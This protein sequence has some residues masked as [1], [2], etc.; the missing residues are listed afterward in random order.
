MIDNTLFRTV[1]YHPDEHQV[2]TSGTDR[3]VSFGGAQCRAVTISIWS[4]CLSCEPK[5]WYAVEKQWS[6]YQWKQVDF[7][8]VPSRMLFIS[9]QILFFPSCLDSN[10]QETHKN[11]SYVFLVSIWKVGMECVD[12]ERKWKKK[13]ANTGSQTHVVHLIQ[14]EPSQTPWVKVQPGVAPG[15]SSSYSSPGEGHWA[16]EI[17]FSMQVV[18]IILSLARHTEPIFCGRPYQG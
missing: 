8:F 10:P 13:K 16:F 1:C 2:I 14:A 12:L 3:K 6:L 7:F 11:N 18:W 15:W 17:T 4:I 5:C 9:I